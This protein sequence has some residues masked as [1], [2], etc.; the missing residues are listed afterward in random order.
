MS[1]RIPKSA[2]DADRFRQVTLFYGS[3]REG[4]K[5][6]LNHLPGAKQGGVLL[7]GYVGWSAREGSGVFDPIRETGVPYT[8]YDLNRDLSVNLDS[9]QKKLD[10]AKFAVL[11][12]IHYFGRTEPRLKAI[13][14]IAEERGVSLVEDLAH[15]FFTAQGSG[16][17]GRAGDMCLFSLHKQFP[18]DDG[19]M[20]TYSDPKLIS[21]QT[22]TRPDL[23][24][25][26]FSYDWRKIADARRQ[27]FESLAELLISLPEYGHYF[28]LPWPRL[29]DDDVPQSLPVYILGEGRDR[30]YAQMNADGFGMVSLYHTLTPEVGDEFPMLSDISRHITNFPVHQD[31][32]VSQLGEMVESFRSCFAEPR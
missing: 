15:G 16:L 27:N 30:I 23:A 19:G 2:V 8:F 18:F 17:A 14:H 1:I 4:M 25:Q 3:A 11:V 5:D 21:G 13:R 28:E 29:D 26:V 7:P 31:I 10:T 12:V 20:V 22:E 9:L 24:S 32:D 6:F